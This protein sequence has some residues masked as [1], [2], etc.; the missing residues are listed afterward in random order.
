MFQNPAYIFAEIWYDVY[1]SQMLNVYYWPLF[2][3]GQEDAVSQNIKQFLRG[4]ICN[5]R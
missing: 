4:N 1:V 2:L 5:P 3:A